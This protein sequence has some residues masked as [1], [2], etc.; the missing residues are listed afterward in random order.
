VFYFG[1]SLNV[2]SAEKSDG[3]V[4][5]LIFKFAG[6]FQQHEKGSL[7]PDKCESF[8]SAAGYLICLL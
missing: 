7:L 4:G 6:C 8:L 1:L 3:A 5:L 2:S